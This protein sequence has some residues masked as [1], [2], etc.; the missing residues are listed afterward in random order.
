M[1]SEMDTLLKTAAVAVPAALLGLTIRRGSPEI[2][3]L[4]GLAAAVCAFFLASGL[5]REI[6]DFLRE[7]AAFPGVNADAVGIVLKTVGIAMLTRISS[8]I[9]RDSGQSALSSGVEAAG[10]AAALYTALPLMRGALKM[11]E[12]VL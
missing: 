12:S 1:G 2:S 8:D 4:L 5:L 3:V 6:T 10:A 9:C 11:V 7:L